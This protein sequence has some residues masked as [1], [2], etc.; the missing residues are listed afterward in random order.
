MALQRSATL[1]SKTHTARA[2]MDFV[3]QH[4]IRAM[5]GPALSPDSNPIEHLWDEIHRRLSQVVPRPT[6]H[7]EL[8]AA[9]LRVFASTKGFQEPPR[10]EQPRRA[11][12]VL[13]MSCPPCA[14][15]THY[16]NT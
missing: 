8:E 14:G 16:N 13:N 6:T 4:Y 12:P 15:C 11:C 5:P 10:F 7:A 1:T 3:R 9:F 2:T